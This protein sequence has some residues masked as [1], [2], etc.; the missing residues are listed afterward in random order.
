MNEEKIS[1][2]IL[3]FANALESVAVKLKH[4]EYRQHIHEHRY[5]RRSHK[6][7]Q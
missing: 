7:D 5:S 3:D 2:A 1:E 6:K 4:Q